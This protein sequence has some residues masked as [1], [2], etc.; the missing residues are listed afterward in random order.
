[1]SQER[2]NEGIKDERETTTHQ[3]WVKERCAMN[4][5]PTPYRIEIEQNTGQLRDNKEPE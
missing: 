4:K 1:M 2:V 5:A 3:I